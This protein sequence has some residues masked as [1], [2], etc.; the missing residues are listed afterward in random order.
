MFIKVEFVFDLSEE[1]SRNHHLGGD[2]RRAPDDNR[3]YGF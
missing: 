2:K 1:K 3:E